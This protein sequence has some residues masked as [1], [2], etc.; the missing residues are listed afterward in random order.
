[1]RIVG[2]MRLLILGGT[3]FLCYHTTTAALDAGHEVFIFNR[4]RTRPDA[5]PTA[6][7]LIGDRKGG[8]LAALE[9]VDGF[10]AVIDCTGYFPREVHEAAAKLQGRTRR[11]LFVSSISVY[12]LDALHSDGPT[13]EDSPVSSLPEGSDETQITGET[14]GPLKV[15][16]EQA[17]HDAF[18]T[19]SVVVR[20]GLIVGPLDPTDRFTYWVRRGFEG[21][22]ILAPG[23][24]TD[25]VQVVDGRDLA[26][27][28]VDLALGEMSGTFNGVAPPR[29]F[30]DLLDACVVAEQ[31][32]VRWVPDQR[33]LDAGV[34]PWVD[35]PLW[36]A[37][38][39]IIASDSRAVAAGLRTRSLEETVSDTRAWDQ[40]R[41]A[42]DLRAGLSREREAELLA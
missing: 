7:R 28:M 9:T 27:W 30:G 39:E 11:Y 29:T 22:T 17:A 20:P 25:L 23:K 15:Q 41:G 33:L 31:A 35:L 40:E 26:A 12:D 5:F 14:Y 36:I 24:P 34:T 4:G 10:D 32:E 3:G 42:P 18:G 1:M 13:T 6:T 38:G 37:D 21:G 16:C 2:G 19:D 8:D